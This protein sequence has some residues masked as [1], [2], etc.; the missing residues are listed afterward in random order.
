MPTQEM[1]A[2]CREQTTVYVGAPLDLSRYRAYYYGPSQ[3]QWRNGGR[4]IVC[5]VRSADNTKLHGS[6]KGV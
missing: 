1:I 4:T 2:S 6:I 5:A 3:L